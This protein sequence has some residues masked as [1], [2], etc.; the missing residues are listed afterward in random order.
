MFLVGIM[1]WWYNRGFAVRF[2]I[3][4]SR[5]KATA[6]LFSIKI[7]LSTLFSPYKQISAEYIDGSI[8]EKIRAFFDRLLSRMVGAVARSF[9]ILVGIIIMATQVLFGGVIMIIWVFIPTLPVIGLLLWAI[10]WIPQ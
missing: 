10:D 3:I 9:M 7:L 8:N 5:V 6:N 2:R 4:A 1:S